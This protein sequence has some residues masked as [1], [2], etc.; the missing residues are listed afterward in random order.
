MAS[1]SDLPVPELSQLADIAQVFHDAQVLIEAERLCQIANHRTR[2]TRRLAE[3]RR[4]TRRRRHHTA[5]N[6]K[7]RGFARTIWSDQ[8]EDFTAMNFQIK[9]THDFY[10]AVAFAQAA[11]PDSDVRF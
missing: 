1:L 5:Q 6:L 3:N 2:I 11:N 9:A 7:H 4:F 10:F 8:T